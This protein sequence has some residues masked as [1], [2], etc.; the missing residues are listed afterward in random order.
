MGGGGGS[1]IGGLELEL[2]REG[3]D[4][5]MYIC[6]GWISYGWDSVQL[7]DIDNISM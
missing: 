6:G 2:E 1:I 4:V 7:S 3:G 5:V